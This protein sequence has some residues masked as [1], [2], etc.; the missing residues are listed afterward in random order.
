MITV[1]PRE[2]EDDGNANIA[3]GVGGGGY[4]RCIMVYVKKVNESSPTFNKVCEL[5]SL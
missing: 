5:E 3:A 1:V 2:I 4:T